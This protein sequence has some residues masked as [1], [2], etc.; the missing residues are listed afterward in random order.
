MTATF[1][2]TMQRHDWQHLQQNRK[3]ADLWRAFAILLAMLAVLGL[4][5]YGVIWRIGMPG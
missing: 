3:A 1:G 2:V 4:I 5:H